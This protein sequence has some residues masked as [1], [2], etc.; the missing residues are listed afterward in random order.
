MSTDLHFTPV[1]VRPR[2]DGWTPLRQ[3]MFVLALADTRCIVAAARVVGMSWQTAYR[4][5]A[6]PDAGSFAAA[7]DRALA[8]PPVAHGVGRAID[9]IATP[10]RYLGRQIGER[11]R[12]DN[13]L[14][15]YLLGVRRPDRQGAGSE[16]RGDV[17]RTSSPS[18]PDAGPFAP[19]Y[20]RRKRPARRIDAGAKVKR[21]VRSQSRVPS[22]RPGRPDPP[23]PPTPQCRRPA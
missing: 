10:I 20:G 22:P 14:A 21:G 9:G 15:M 16:F 6:R 3:T 1:P 4:L 23:R 11:R 7:W 13:R 17:A 8:P 2:R 19:S 5:R 12:H 18:A